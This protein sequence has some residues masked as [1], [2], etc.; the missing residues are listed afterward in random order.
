MI[1]YEDFGAVGDGVADDL[2]AICKAHEHANSKGL[3]IK[4]NPSAKYHLGRKAL[5][6]TIATDTDWST[7][8]L[9]IDDTDVENHRKSLFEVFDRG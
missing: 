8:R 9:T 7:S 2:P 1:T 5:T 4:S 6:A 3:P